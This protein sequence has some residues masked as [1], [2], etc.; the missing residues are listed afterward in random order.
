MAKRAK[1][2][3]VFPTNDN[4]V[5]VYA[6]TAKTRYYR[7]SFYLPDNP[8]QQN[9]TLGRD[10]QWALAWSEAK[11]IELRSMQGLPHADRPYSTIA[12]LI[13]AYIDPDRNGLGW[14]HRTLQKNIEI[15][16][17]IPP[18]IKKL[19]CRS[20]REETLQDFLDSFA[21]GHKPSYTRTV[22]GFLT[23]MVR[24]G[25]R[26]SWFLSDQM[27]ELHFTIKRSDTDND[28][29]IAIDP[30]LLPTFDEFDRLI[31]AIE[32]PLY[33]LMCDLTRGSGF[34]FGEVIG[35]RK[36]DVNLRTGKIR[37][38]R[39]IIE[40]NS[41]RSRESSTKNRRTRTVPF[42]LRLAPALKER[43]AEL[44]DPDALLFTAPKGGWVSRNN[45]G[46]RVFRPAI[47]TAGLGSQ[48]VHFHTLRHCAAAG[49][50][51]RGMSMLLVSQTLGHSDPGVTERIY[52]K[53]R[54]DYSDDAAA[55]FGWNSAA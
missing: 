55:A 16:K 43:L 30:D 9:T 21:T 37:V 29:D 20:L 17:L 14:K 42:E 12:E 46:R 22:R 53:C 18:T 39:S 54:R 26:R 52:A 36:K 3:A 25:R 48:L 32:D 49:M 27:K 15:A 4:P 44:D 6:P 2:I 47:Q 19:Q 31:A 35:L 7:A 28:D 34:R 51:E 45:F 1:P 40:D 38:E 41:G 5:R 50:L 24:F 23:G 13:R 8:R 33:R 11:A 10:R